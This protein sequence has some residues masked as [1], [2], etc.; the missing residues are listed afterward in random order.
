M[1]KLPS[2]YLDLPLFQ[3][4]NIGNF[5]EKLVD[6]FRSKL[7]DWRSKWLSSAGRIVKTKAILSALPIFW[8]GVFWIPRNILDKLEQIMRNFLWQGNFETRKAHLVAWDLVCS[9]NKKG[10][11]GIRNIWIMNLALLGK[12]IWCIYKEAQSLW[13][14]TL[15]SKYLDSPE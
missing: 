9:E 5:W 11:L 7:I 8:M 13:S 10:G 3:G 12:L 2:T 6:K 15:R 4:G 14:I 1:D